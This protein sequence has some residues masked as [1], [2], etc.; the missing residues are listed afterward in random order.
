[1]RKTLLPLISLLILTTACRSKDSEPLL[2][3]LLDT[4]SKTVLIL[5]GTYASDRPL[6]FTEINGNQLFR[7]ADDTSLD[8]AGLPAYSDLPIYLDIG[9]VRLS[10]RD[11]GT[12]LWGI[13]TAKDAKAFWD[14]I[15]S[16]RQVY[17]S[18][19]YSASLENDSCYATGGLI[20]YQEFMNGR[21]ALYPSRDVDATNITTSVQYEPDT[22]DALKQ[23]L[24]PQWFPLHFNSIMSNITPNAMIMTNEQTTRV[25]E[26]RFNMKENMMVHGVNDT[27]GYRTVVA[28]SDWRKGHAQ[29]RDLGGNVLMR[30]R[31][32][33]P[34]Y[35]NTLTITGGTQNP[36][37]YY[38]IVDP[39]E[40]FIEDNLPVAATPVRNGSN[41]I[42]NLMGGVNYL[43]QCRYDANND[44]YPETL[45]GPGTTFGVLP[46]PGSLTV[47]CPCGGSTT[48]GC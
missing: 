48:S 6:E 14:V 34:D 18:Q 42:Q 32:Y 13:E 28:F 43:L 37:F 8:V 25:V 5:K 38:A 47:D 21:G 1:M 3:M 29:Q 41:T 33:Y 39:M 35:V 17:C 19:P 26:I 23:L 15:S 27:N 36:R 10:S 44:G 46:G 45:V 11:Y 4:N 16:E 2:S 9:E 24:A 31:V 30:A 7:D 12:G 20:N 22:N 40:T